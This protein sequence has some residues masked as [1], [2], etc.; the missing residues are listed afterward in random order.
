M[1]LLFDPKPCST[2]EDDLLEAGERRVPPLRYGTMPMS[3][4]SSDSIAVPA[5]MAF[6]RLIV[7]T[8]LPRTSTVPESSLSR[9]K[10]A[11]TT[12]RQ[13]ADRERRLGVLLLEL[14]AHH[15]RYHNIV[16]GPV[17]PVR[18]GHIAIAEDRDVVRDPKASS[19]LWEM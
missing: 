18:A 9:P 4:R 7:S 6:A 3:R 11:C 5:P 16:G 14:A 12:S 2:P 15:A 17:G 8:R 10:I 1:E 13:V 19:I